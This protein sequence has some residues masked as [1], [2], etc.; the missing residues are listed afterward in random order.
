MLLTL[1]RETK[2]STRRSEDE[3]KDVH[4][5]PLSTSSIPQSISSSVP[6]SVLPGVALNVPISVPSAESGVSA[7][8][9]Q[10][11]AEMELHA[12]HQVLYNYCCQGTVVMAMVMGDAGVWPTGWLKIKPHTQKSDVIWQPYIV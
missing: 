5:L 11:Q 10:Y 4:K 8:Q 1:D 9:K 12:K 3:P 6:S 2:S 7:L